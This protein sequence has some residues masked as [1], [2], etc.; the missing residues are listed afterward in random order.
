MLLLGACNSPDNSIASDSSITPSPTSILD[1]P[2]IIPSSKVDQP[3]AEPTRQ[4]NLPATDEPYPGP[5]AVGE[6]QPVSTPDPYPGPQT[7]TPAP[8][9]G[10]AT[11]DNVYMPITSSADETATPAH[12]ATPTPTAVPTLDFAAIQSDLWANGQDLGFV[13]IG[14]HTTIL[15]ER[16]V[17]DS[18]MQ[19]LDQAGVP[20]FLKTVDNAEPIF[21]AQELM[22]ESG[23]PHTLVFR[24]S[25]SVPF[26]EL[27]AAQAAQLHWEEHRKKFPPELDPSVVWIETLNEPDRTRAEWL[28]QFA[29]ETARLA[30]A[31]GFRW[32]AFGWASGEPEPEHW[33]TPGMLAFLRLA[34]EN[35]DRLAVALHEYSYLEDD[36]AHEYPYKVGR[37]Q[38]LFRIADAQ[39]FP[40]PTVLI[41]EWGWQYNDIPP[42]GQVMD[43]LKWAAELYAQYPQVK[44]VGIWNLGTGCC[45]GDISEQ[46][47]EI[48]DPVTAFS[49]N[50]Y[51]AIP[52]PPDQQA[53]DPQKFRP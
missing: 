20:I 15:E 46:V 4:V 47:Q 26:Y 37:F 36:L 43:E 39:G 33:Q 18:W 48:I 16:G 32:A 11:D 49:L 8:P 12:T 6:N 7:S 17:L 21:K 41:T 53:V 40:R 35:P 14:F 30:M 28:G 34:G 13:K 52:Q 42:V 45:Y 1:V 51:Y 27:P 44:G 22:K 5:T 3:T 19:Q 50:N 31:D 25:G 10:G 29:Q 24:S 2:T 23:V 38:E 9:D